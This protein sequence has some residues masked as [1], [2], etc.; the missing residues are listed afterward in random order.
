MMHLKR[1]RYALIG[2]VALLA[3]GTLTAPQ[4]AAAEPVSPSIQADAAH[5]R[6]TTVARY[7][8]EAWRIARGATLSTGLFAALLIALRLAQAIPSLKRFAKEAAPAAARAA[9]TAAAAPVKAAGAAAKAA[10]AAVGGPFR[11]AAW[12]FAAVLLL[13]M[14]ISLLHA[15]WIFGVAV[16]AG[17]ALMAVAGVRK[18]AKGL[19]GLRFG[20]TA[21]A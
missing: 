21:A 6:A 17:A 3:G 16:G 8:S 10:G 13:V 2:S 20:K 5:L 19:T 12:I 1:L 4:D 18:C 14:S 15:E 7:E 9:K 11:K